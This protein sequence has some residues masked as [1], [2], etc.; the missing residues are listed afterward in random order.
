MK[1]LQTIFLLMKKIDKNGD[2]TK[3]HLKEMVK[4]VLVQLIC[5]CIKPT[6]ATYLLP[7][8][9]MFNQ[10]SHGFIKTHTWNSSI[11]AFINI[12]ASGSGGTGIIFLVSN[13]FHIGFQEIIMLSVRFT[14]IFVT[15]NIS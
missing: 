13:V 7:Y 12:E 8:S 2:L 4:I 15:S 14:S 1:V 11:S 5:S 6:E 10:G 9:M 3:Q